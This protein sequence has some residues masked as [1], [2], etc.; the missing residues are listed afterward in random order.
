MRLLPLPPADT[1]WRVA[2]AE[3]MTRFR[4]NQKGCCCKVWD[5]DFLPVEVYGILDLYPDH[6]HE[7]ILQELELVVDHESTIRRV[8][9][10]RVGE[11]KACQF[12][13][14]EGGCSIQGKLGAR[15]L[16]GLCA[17]YPGFGFERKDGVVELYFDAICPEV[18]NQ[19]DEEDAPLQFVETE[20]GP[21]DHLALRA[22]RRWP[23]PPTRIGERSVSPSELDEIRARILAEVVT[24]SESAL[25]LL[26]RISEAIT[27]LARDDE[28]T[29][30]SFRIPRESPGVAFERF[31][32]DCLRTHDG[33]LLTASLNR[34]ARFVFDLPAAALTEP[35]LTDELGDVSGWREQ[36]DPRQP[37]LQP[38]L[39]RYLSQRYF[40]PY[41]VSRKTGELSFTYGSLAHILA[42][43][44][45]YAGAFT[46]RLERPLDRVIMKTAIGASEYFYRMMNIPLDALPWY[47]VEVGPR[48][49]ADDG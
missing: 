39:R 10:K 31:F 20:A 1:V 19:L 5:I 7:E 48:E 44:F 49:E 14:D 30:P 17:A 21:D 43:A 24:S 41:A 42:T 47:G 29:I 15:V 13:C 16:P 25:D 45:R 34:Y 23:R 27:T 11:E 38:L 22:R 12:L 2:V 6:Q 28:A 46:K 37:D 26:G 18:L 3:S 32:D 33:R 40:A 4:C 9:L 35:P 8:R 36:I